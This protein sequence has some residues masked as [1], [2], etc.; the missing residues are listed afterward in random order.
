MKLAL[1][2]LPALLL[3]CQSQP[4]RSP[5]QQ[6]ADFGGL[7]VCVADHWGE[8]IPQLAGDC[9]Q[10]EEQAAADFVADIG[11][12]FSKQS[13]PAALPA[14][15]LKTPSVQLAMKKRQGSKP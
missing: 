5:T 1:C 7:A 13:P 15:W 10:S 12:I 14:E 11:A 9:F 6:V 4:A 3:S 2:V 8:P